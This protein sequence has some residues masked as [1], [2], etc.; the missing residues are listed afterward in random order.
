MKV[1]KSENEAWVHI[2]KW[3]K[4]GKIEEKYN[5]HN[6]TP[7]LKINFQVIERGIVTII[8]SGW[9]ILMGEANKVQI[10]HIEAMQSIGMS[11]GEV[12]DCLFGIRETA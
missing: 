2:E 6:T 7:I 1:T 4:W 3:E 11:M 12:E 8:N 10:G 9:I 5:V